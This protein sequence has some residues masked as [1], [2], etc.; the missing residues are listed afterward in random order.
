[1]QIILSKCRSLCRGAISPA[2]WYPDALPEGCLRPMTGRFAGPLTG[3]LFLIQVY[4]ERE[5]M[6]LFAREKVRKS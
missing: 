3:L 6:F 1:M 5:Y 2:R 4:H